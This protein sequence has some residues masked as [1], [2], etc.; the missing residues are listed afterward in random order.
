VVPTCGNLSMN[1]ITSDARAEAS[2]RGRLQQAGFS[3]LRRVRAVGESAVDSRSN[4]ASSV[5]AETAGAPTTFEVMHQNLPLM[6]VDQD[7]G[8]DIAVRAAQQATGAAGAALALMRDGLLVCRARVGSLAPSL[9][10]VLD[11][12][13]G[14]TA[15]CVR[16]GEVLYCSDA[17]TDVVVD[18]CLCRELNIR[19]I[20]VVPIAE[21]K[22]VTGVLEVLSPQADAFNTA[23]V[24]WLMQVAK[25]IALTQSARSASPS[26]A[27]ARDRGVSVL[28]PMDKEAGRG[29]P[30]NSADGFNGPQADPAK[31]ELTVI[32]DILQHSAETRSWHEI[33][34]QLESRLSIHNDR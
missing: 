26:Q 3:V 33:W 22:T 25:F 13:A 30:E 32:S 20:L 9:G 15:A 21:A 12:T 5:A 16:T 23:H 18:R 24:H 6:S 31:T 7:I 27:T 34:Q 29:H 2:C 10:I 11:E 17:E 28:Q 1:V 14:I 4:L 19:S 8:L